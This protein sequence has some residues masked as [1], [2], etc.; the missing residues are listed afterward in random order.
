MTRARDL[1]KKLKSLGSEEQ[2]VV[3]RRFFKTG[4]GEYGEGDVFLGP[5]CVLTNVMNPRSQ[6]VRRGLYE[7]TILRRGVTI[8]ANATVICGIEL[9]RYCFIAAGAVVTRDLPA[10]SIA[11]GV[12]AQIVGERGADA[13]PAEEYG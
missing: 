12:P 10:Y 3:S 11:R 5:S 13:T 7:K 1:K 6:I 8:G 4:P 2:A 9:G